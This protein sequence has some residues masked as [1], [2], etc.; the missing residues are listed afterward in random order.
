METI[1]ELTK[2]SVPSG[3]W[4]IQQSVAVQGGSF[5]N[6][7]FSWIVRAP[8]DPTPGSMYILAQV[9]EGLLSGLSTS[10]PGFVARSTGVESGEWVFDPSVTLAAGRTYWF[11]ASGE[12]TVLT[13]PLG[14]DL[15][16]DGELYVAGTVEFDNTFRR[17]HVSSPNDRIDANFRLR[18]AR[19]P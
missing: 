2:A 15:Y 6:I 9:Y 19:V 13:S 18:G 14:P 10:V 12:T 7:H 17:F 16:P 3:P 5:N 1:A 8:E 11:A 4:A